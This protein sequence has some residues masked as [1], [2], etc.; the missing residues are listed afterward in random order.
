LAELLMM[1][2]AFHYEALKAALEPLRCNGRPAADM[3]YS[4]LFHR[5]PLAVSG[6]QLCVMNPQTDTG[7]EYVLCCV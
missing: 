1:T 4:F 6:F 7:D 5:L 2:V 3:L